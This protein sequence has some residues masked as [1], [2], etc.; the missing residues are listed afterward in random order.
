M[1]VACVGGGPAGLYF[2][3]SMKLR[4]SAHDVTIFERNAAGSN[5]G[6]GVTFGS[7]LMERLYATDPVSARGIDEAAFRQ[8]SQVVDIHGR[9]V[10]QPGERF[11]SIGRQR[12][13]DIL[14]D[15]AQ[16]LGVRIEFDQEVKTPAQLPEADLIV[17]CDGVHSRTRIEAGTFHTDV[18]V[19]SNKYIWLGTPK[20]FESFTYAFVSTG[21]GWVWAY[22]YPID[23]ESSTFI[24]E[25]SAQTWT[26]LGFDTATPH[27]SLALLEKLF[28]RHLDNKQL[29]GRAHRGVNDGNDGWLNF[30]SVTNRRW[31]DG[32]IVL[33][34]DAAHTT[35]FTIGSGTTLAIEDAIALAEDLQRHSRLE[36]ALESYQRQRQAALQGPQSDARFSAQWFENISRYVDLKPDEFSALLHGRRSPLLPHLPPHFYYQLHHATEEITVLRRLRRRMAP[37]A[38]AIYSRRNPVQP[39]GDSEPRECLKRWN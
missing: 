23:A 26:G 22:G 9:Q 3:L 12:L 21:S 39:G 18:S 15:R 13:L 38:K 19:G 6:W 8:V 11:Y 32:N 28:A 4:D 33:A 20:V 31:Y 35:H 1:K 29:F 27:D 37:T 36:Q 14:A 30:R 2:A 25:C 5:H 17:A 24:V 10:L 7:D 34:G 16:G